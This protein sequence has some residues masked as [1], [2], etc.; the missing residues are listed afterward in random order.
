MQQQARMAELEQK[1]AELAALKTPP[2]P[3]ARANRPQPEKAEGQ[4]RKK[5]APE[6]NHGRRKMTPTRIVRHA[7]ERCPEC[8]YALHGAAVGRRREVIDLPEAPVVV[9]EHQFIKRYCPV[10]QA[11]RTPRVQLGEEVV[12]QGRIGIRLMSLIG[13][14]RLVHR[15]PLARVQELLTQVYGLTLSQGGL[16]HVLER[17]RAGLAPTHA[18][19]VAE[20]RASPS[21]HLDET[22][23]RENGQNGYLW[24]EATAGSRPTRVFTYR[25]SRAGAVA[26]ELIGDYDGVLVTDGYVAYDHVPC[27]KQ[28]CWT[29]ILRTGREIREKHPQD[30]LL[31][32]WTQGSPVSSGPQRRPG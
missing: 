16:C 25:P 17:L 7:Y 3:W 29:H 14:L 5:R 4:T 30:Q 19:I 22:G 1:V 15:L 26:D 21:R 11:W 24:V 12:G 6:H 20:S 10:C 18:A 31:A 27:A 28:R 32:L 8:D 9:T 2:P 13:V 23:W